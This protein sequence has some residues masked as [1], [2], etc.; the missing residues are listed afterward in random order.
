LEKAERLVELCKA[1]FAVKGKRKDAASFFL[2]LLGRDDNKPVKLNNE[3]RNSHRL[4]LKCEKC[5]NFRLLV[6]QKFEFGEEIWYVDR[7]P[8]FSSLMHYSLPTKDGA[9]SF[10]PGIYKAKKVVC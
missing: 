8:N 10:C 2:K 1:E 5:K 9:F 4:D 7:D 3:K 6:R